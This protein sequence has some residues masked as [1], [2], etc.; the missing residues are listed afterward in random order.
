MKNHWL[1][2]LRGFG[3]TPT[4]SAEGFEHWRVKQFH[5]HYLLKGDDALVGAIMELASVLVLGLCLTVHFFFMALGSTILAHVWVWAGRPSGA[6]P[7]V[8]VGKTIFMF[9]LRSP[10][11]LHFGFGLELQTLHH[12]LLK[13]FKVL[14]LPRTGV[15]ILL[16]PKVETLII[17]DGCLV[18]TGA[19]YVLNNLG[20]GHQ[21]WNFL[22][23]FL[24]INCHKNMETLH[25]FQRCIDRVL[26]SGLYKY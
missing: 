6:G 15:R 25:P 26:V 1:G 4:N 21:I 24:R 20:I 9:C 18:A 23:N 2:N 17:C 12:S 3:H 11:G 19:R 8:V 16:A 14:L 13:K 10:K 5:C 22:W 7:S